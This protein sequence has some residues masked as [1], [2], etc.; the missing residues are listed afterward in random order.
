ML[1]LKVPTMAV[2][3]GPCVAVVLLF[4]LAHDF[5][6]MHSQA[7]VGLSVIKHGL[8]LTDE[9]MSLLRALVPIHRLRIMMYDE[10]V[11]AVVAYK[12]KI[13]QGLYSTKD[14]A[15]AKVHEFGDVFANDVFEMISIN[16][17]NTFANELKPEAFDSTL[18]S[19][20][21]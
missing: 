8:V 4:A 12:D 2:I 16:K 6:I 19:L 5:R 20:I 11:P 15:L 3:H 17:R 10:K 1:T 7:Q 21:L 13:V 14:E 18:L 9:H